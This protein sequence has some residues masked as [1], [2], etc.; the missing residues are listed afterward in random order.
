MLINFYPAIPLNVGLP[1]NS[2]QEVNTYFLTVWIRKCEDKLTFN[3]IWV[4]AP[5]IGTIE[6]KLF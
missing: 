6:T 5:T 4:F 3:H 2:C 1:Q